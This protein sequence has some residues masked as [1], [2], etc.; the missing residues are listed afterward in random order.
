MA[1]SEAAT[2][3]SAAQT[4]ISDTDVPSSDDGLQSLS[5]DSDDDFETADE[6]IV[7]G[8]NIT[9]VSIEELPAPQS[10]SDVHGQNLEETTEKDGE[11]DEDICETDPIDSKKKKKPSQRERRLRR[12]ALLHQRQHL[13]HVYKD[14]G[15]V[16]AAAVTQASTTGHVDLV[17]KDAMQKLLTE[18]SGKR[19][20]TTKEVSAATGPRQE[21]WKLAGEAELTNN[22][23]KLGA[24]HEST[25][26]EKA[27]HGR[28][29]PMM[30]VWSEDGDLLK[31]RACVCGNIEEVDPTQQSWTAQAE[32]S[33][34]FGV[35]KLGRMRRWAISKHDVKGAFLN[36]KIPDGKLVIVSPPP[37]WVKWGLVPPGTLWTLDAAVYGLRESPKW[38]GDERDKQLRNVKWTDTKMKR[39]YF[40][41]RCSADSQLWFIRDATPD[42]KSVV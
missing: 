7:Q 23:L 29:L 12:Q 1:W 11:Q 4:E 42:R 22:F 26:T 38:W 34:L 32:P 17:N 19:L 24:F 15:D 41:E 20:V 27:A 25:A 39:P 28:P 35:L 6:W 8:G 30:C 16:F 33:S 36:A 18:E 10:S 5:E 13:L 14:Q 40:L 2:W 21:R 37:I 9:P 31:C 3:G